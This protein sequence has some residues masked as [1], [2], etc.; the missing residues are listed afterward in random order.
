VDILNVALFGMSAK[1]WRDANPERKGN[2]RDEADISQ[3]VCLANLETLNALF[4]QEGLGQ[5]ERLQKLNTIAIGQMKIL[6]SEK[7]KK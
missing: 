3:L 1:E 4:I 7:I 6:S 2:I 5:K